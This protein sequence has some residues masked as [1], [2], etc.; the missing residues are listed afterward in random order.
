V[1]RVPF[2]QVQAR[3][4][5]HWDPFVR[6]THQ[7]LIGPTGSGKSHLIRHGI[8]PVRPHAR[9]VVIDSKGGT[10]PIW[11]GW[12]AVT[13]LPAAFGRDRDGGGPYGMRYRLVVNP[14]DAKRQVRRALDQVR[15]ERHTILVVDETRSVSEGEQ[16]GARSALERLILESRSSGVTA[17]LGAQDASWLP[18]AVKSQ[19]AVLWIA[20]QRSRKIARVLA[21]LSG[22]GN[23]LITPITRTPNR[24]WIV[25]DAWDA[26]PIIGV[27]EVVSA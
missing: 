25:S 7:A 4:D 1:P 13:E 11:A 15:T 10:D 12:P 14:A 5:R 18:A 17:I 24:T 22:W 23:E 19:P 27:T 2:A 8:L 16:I 20:R 21:D 26:E 6:N 9:V 3:L